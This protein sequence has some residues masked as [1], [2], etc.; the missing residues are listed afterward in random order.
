[1]FYQFMAALEQ[2]IEPDELRKFATLIIKSQSIREESWS[3]TERH[4]K[5]SHGEAAAQVNVEINMSQEYLDLAC[6][7]NMSAW[8]DVQDWALGILKNQ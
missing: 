7:L 5:L 1:M 3:E 8:N 4:Y 6:T 2:K